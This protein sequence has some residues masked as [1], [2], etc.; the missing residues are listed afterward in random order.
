[1]CVLMAAELVELQALENSN[2]SRTERLKYVRTK[3]FSQKEEFLRAV[4]REGTDAVSQNFS[5]LEDMRRNFITGLYYMVFPIEV[6]PLSLAD[7][8]ADGKN[9]Y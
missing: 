3:N 9:R 8:G 1:M 4:I 5:N 2:K 7:E 6:L